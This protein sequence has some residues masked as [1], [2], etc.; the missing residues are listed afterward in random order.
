VL[1]VVLYQCSLGKYSDNLQ[2]LYRN[3]NENLEELSSL[4][5]HH[6]D[7]FHTQEDDSADL[8]QREIE[9]L[10]EIVKETDVMGARLQYE[11]GALVNKIEDVEDSMRDFDRFL[12]EAENKIDAYE[13]ESRGRNGWWDWL[14]KV[15][16]GASDLT[17]DGMLE[18][19]PFVGRRAERDEKVQ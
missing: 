10:T 1:L 19:R 13:R 6:L 8:M 15:V 3:I 17:T 18:E 12:E 16:L 4:Y 14:M 5:H 9:Q 2:D 7:T 11:L